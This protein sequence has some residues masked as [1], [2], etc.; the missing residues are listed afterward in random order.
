VAACAAQDSETATPST[1]PAHQPLCYRIA[2]VTDP[3]PAVGVKQATDVVPWRFLQACACASCWVMTPFVAHA[4][5]DSKVELAP[6]SSRNLGRAGLRHRFALSA[7]R[8]V[9]AYVRLC[10]TVEAFGGCEQA[11]KQAG[12]HAH[13][14]A[15]FAKRRWQ[16]QASRSRLERQE[17]KAVLSET[18]WGVRSNVKNVFKVIISQKLTVRHTSAESAPRSIVCVC[19]V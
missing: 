19:V 18:M 4:R 15:R 1:T 9:T 16:A 12:R 14:P 8:G 13:P 2:G 5:E 11:S 6:H 10:C 17:W 3:C 7:V